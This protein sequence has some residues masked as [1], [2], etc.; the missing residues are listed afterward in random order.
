MNSITVNDLFCASLSG[1]REDEA[2]WDAVRQLHKL[3]T[4][5]VLDKAIALTRSSDPLHRARGADILGQLGVSTK[6]STIFI[7]KRLQSLLEL[8]NGESDP[9]VLDA[10]IVALGHLRKAEGIKAILEYSD[11]P[12]E[13]VRFAVAWALPGGQ[14]DNPEITQTLLLLM[15]DHD[16]DVRDWA[17]FG[18][19]TQSETDSPAIREALFERLLDEDYDTRA[20][21]AA[22]L[23]KRK[24]KR[25]LPILLEEL[26]RDEYGS[27]YEEAASSL[28][29][30][31]IGETEGWES[32]RYIEELRK[33]FNVQNSTDEPVQ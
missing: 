32:C 30:L 13:N 6:P 29:G 5:E 2:A 28:L 4:Q 14:G 21:A 18:L 9:V 33:H 24:D 22:G 17:T 19:G 12:D 1:D 15:R 3:G 27:L 20:E 11:H 31:D 7:P 23:A 26:S 16:A 8:L 10:A 25:V